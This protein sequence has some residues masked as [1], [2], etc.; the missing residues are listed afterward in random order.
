MIW[1]YLFQ[2][3]KLFASDRT[4]QTFFESVFNSYSHNTVTYVTVRD[5]FLR[6]RQTNEK[7]AVLGFLS[8]ISCAYYM[9]YLRQAW[10]F[11]QLAQ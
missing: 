5:L 1:K 2:V 7:T 8:A 6:N 4:M 3:H 11:I 9:Y 10:Y